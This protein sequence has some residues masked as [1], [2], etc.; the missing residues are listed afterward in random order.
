[1]NL[2]I[3]IEVCIS[4]IYWKLESKYNKI[5]CSIEMKS[6][7]QDKICGISK[8]QSMVFL[9]QSTYSSFLTPKIVC[10]RTKSFSQNSHLWAVPSHINMIQTKQEFKIQTYNVHDQSLS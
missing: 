7:Q 8:T 5:P 6:K 9:L 10:L 3:T 4:L 1:M 2:K